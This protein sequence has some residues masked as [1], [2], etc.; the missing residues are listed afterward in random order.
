MFPKRLFK[1][2]CALNKNGRLLYTGLISIS[3]KPHDYYTNDH[4]RLAGLHRCEGEVR[5]LHAPL[6]GKVTFHLEM[7]KNSKVCFSCNF[8]LHVSW[9]FRHSH[10]DISRTNVP[11]WILVSVS[12]DLELAML[13]LSHQPWHKLNTVI[14]C[15][16]RRSIV[17]LTFSFSGTPPRGSGRPS[18]QLW[19]GSSTLSWCTEGTT[20]GHPDRDSLIFDPV[21]F[22][23]LTTLI[24]LIRR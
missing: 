1:R 4:D 22:I 14:Y 7:M 21:I 15:L 8:L 17:M 20:V 3:A 12:L 16:S 2:A 6:R 13:F 10:G 24:I 9:E 18:A 19:R 11:D 23:I 5:P